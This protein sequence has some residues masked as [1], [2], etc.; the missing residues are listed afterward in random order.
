MERWQQQVEAELKG[1]GFS[2]LVEE[3][4][5][6]VSILPLYSAENVAELSLQQDLAVPFARGA[7]PKAVTRTWWLAPR[8]DLPHPRSLN[9]VI[10]AE[11]AGG[12]DACWLQLDACAR[13][14]EPPTSEIGRQAWGDG[15]CMLWTLEDWRSFLDGVDLSALHMELDAGANTMASAAMLLVVA[16]EQGLDISALDWNLGLDPL[17]SLARDGLLPLG[18]RCMK[19]QMGDLLR[20]TANHM[21]QA[22]PVCVS[23]EVYHGAGATLVQELGIFAATLVHYLQLAESLDIPLAQMAQGISLRLVL[24]RDVFPALAGLRAARQ[25]WS[26]VCEL[27]EVEPPSPWIHAIG[28]RRS[29]SQK[30]PWTNQLRA[31]TQTFAAIL[32][33]A[34][35]ITTCTYDEVLGRPSA[36]GRRI[37]RNTQIILA[38][39]SR[40]GEVLDPAGGSYYVERLTAELCTQAWIFFQKIE[41]AGGMATALRGGWL[42]QVLAAQ[43]QK[44]RSLLACRALAQTGVSTYPLPAERVQTQEPY[45]GNDEDAWASRW[46]PSEPC[47]MRVDHGLEDLIQAAADGCDV[48]ALTEAQ[49]NTFAAFCG[50]PQVE[51]LLLQ[52]DAAMFEEMAQKVERQRQSGT[53]P[54]VLL[55]AVGEQKEAEKPLRQAESLF[56]DLGLP[57]RRISVAARGVLCLCGSASALQQG[58][59]QELV[60]AQQA[61][62]PMVLLWGLDE[63]AIPTGL[64]ATV[65]WRCLHPQTDLPTLVQ[66]ILEVKP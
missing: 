53:L 38:E 14:G 23:T 24:D 25:L 34:Q 4:Y 65:P 37:A 52:R 9:Q 18:A 11:I 60:V 42:H 17:A 27:V 46:R 26:R 20:W 33:G 8:L 39:E 22:R 21:P 44:R 3:A 59:A 28:S 1:A 64:S 5:A 58:L 62:A 29:L 40:L 63:E 61:D 51:P 49:R 36:L 12:A 57:T 47:V 35:Q 54:E 32:G 48:F 19:H 31:N 55:L 43:Q 16:Q 15:G 30:D 66:H 41:A 7:A 10:R 56:H 45:L 50:G 6:G 13:L 2:T